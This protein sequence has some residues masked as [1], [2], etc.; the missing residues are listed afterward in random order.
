MRCVVLTACLAA[1]LAIAKDAPPPSTDK[2]PEMAAAFASRIA[3]RTLKAPGG[4]DVRIGS[5]LDAGR[6]TTC[7]KTIHEGAGWPASWLI[8]S[9]QTIPHDLILRV[10]LADDGTIADP[11]TV[12]LANRR[13][14]DDTF[15]AAFVE[16]TGKKPPKERSRNVV[17]Q[18]FTTKSITDYVYTLPP[19][20]KGA[21]GLLAFLPEG[22]YLRE[23][24]AID[25]GTP[26]RHTVAV[27]FLRPRF[28][29]ADCA[30][31]EGRKTGHRDEGGILIALAGEKALLDSLEITEIVKKATGA[32]MLPKLVC[33]EGD[34]APGAI[35]ML[36][37]SRFA[38]REPVKLL[39]FS[40]KL[41]ESPIDGLPVTV[42]IKR[43]NGKFKVFA[44][45]SR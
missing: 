43:E 22:S 13:E 37:D 9:D 25:L 8:V 23:S 11:S 20:G 12:F 39:D 40:G 1:S 16:A 31:M 45:A 41:A 30:T 10:A 32:A 28:V 15:D 29:P 18:A 21:K 38:G 4:R 5:I 17:L 35:D 34:T 33:A 3:D 2:L 6:M 26:E 19:A 27:V 36:V 24:A 7:L 44:T 14:Y 42:G